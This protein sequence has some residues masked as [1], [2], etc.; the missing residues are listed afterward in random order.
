MINGVNWAVIILQDD[1]ELL[2][3]CQSHIRVWRFTYPSCLTSVLEN[4]TGSKQ[5]HKQL[6][7]PRGALQTV[8]DVRR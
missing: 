4:P 8:C 2:E 6:F 1:K 3:S 7:K 5:G